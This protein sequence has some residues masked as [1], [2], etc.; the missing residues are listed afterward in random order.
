MTHHD[1]MQPAID[2][3]LEAAR[4]REVPIGA[5]IWQ[6]DT[7]LAVG[8][9]RREAT[10]LATS[11]AEIDAIDAACHKLGDWR[12]EGCVIYVTAEP[13]FMCA[14][15]ILQ[16]RME[17]VVFGVLEPKFGALVSQAQVLDT[18]TL[19]HHISFTG[20]I[21]EDEIRQMMKEFFKGL[22]G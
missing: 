3:A 16:A 21:R 1:K 11:H 2:V 14:G 13:C 5:A 7:L 6:G 12:L 19:N 15:A 10:R 8:R 4:N 18:P 17:H 9:N 22:R 20:G